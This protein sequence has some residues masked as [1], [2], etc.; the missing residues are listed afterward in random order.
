MAECEEFLQDVRCRLEKA[1][2]VQKRHYDRIHRAVSYKLGDWV[3]V[4]L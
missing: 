2:T 4:R 3:L 1:Q